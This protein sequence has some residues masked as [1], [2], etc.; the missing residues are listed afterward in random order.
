MNF[1]RGLAADFSPTPRRLSHVPDPEAGIEPIRTWQGD[2]PCLLGSGMQEQGVV[3]PRRQ[4]LA[5][6]LS[7][8][9]KRVS[10]AAGEASLSPLLP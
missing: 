4:L 3:A 9:C 5:A 1:P 8:R 7:Y 2:C 10:E 6:R